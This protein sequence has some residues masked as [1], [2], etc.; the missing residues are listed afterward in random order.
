MKTAKKAFIV[1]S[2][3]IVSA[4]T[5]AF[6]PSKNGKVLMMVTIEVKDYT[7]WKKGFDA[8]APVREKAGIKVLSIC[9]SIENENQIIVIE[10][11]ESAQTA[12]DFLTVLKSRQKAGDMSKLD[13]KLYD[14]AE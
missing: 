3:F 14:K 10:E 4:A 9:R 12:H 8:G 2:L 5:L 6:T 7:E 11:A 1:A 13:V